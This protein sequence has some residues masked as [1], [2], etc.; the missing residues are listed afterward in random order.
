MHEQEKYLIAKL[1]SLAHDIT[2]PEAYDIERE[3]PYQINDIISGENPD[4]YVPEEALEDFLD[5]GASYLY[6][7]L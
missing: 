5:L 3:T 7:F 2:I 1:Y 4:Y 6:I